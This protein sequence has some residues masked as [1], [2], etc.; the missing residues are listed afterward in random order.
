MGCDF[1]HSP[2][3]EGKSDRKHR[4]LQAETRDG[5]R[6]TRMNAGGD[7]LLKNDERAYQTKADMEAVGAQIRRTREK[8][9]MTPEELSKKVGEPCPGEDN[10]Q[11]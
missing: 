6:E 11:G 2:T 8:R 5:T 7:A 4:R 10:P 1:I 9:G 3:F